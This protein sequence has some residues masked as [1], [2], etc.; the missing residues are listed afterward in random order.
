LIEV[1]FYG[2]VVSISDSHILTQKS[3]AMK[4]L[5]IGLLVIAAG[6]GAFYY[7]NQKS[8]DKPEMSS[9]NKELIIGKWKTDAVMA[10]DS[11]FNKYSYNFQNEG[12]ILRSLND[13]ANAD[14]MH[15]EWSKTNDLVW[16]EWTPSEKEK[17]SDS[18]P[19]IYSVIK[20]TQDSLQVQSK[21]SIKVLFTKVK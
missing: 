4:K 17:A 1:T 8:G 6:A 10:N 9:L 3:I 11:G 7:F 5:F 15:Y 13:S 21:D 19:T 14:T 16:S 2:L 12:T 20:L 18:T